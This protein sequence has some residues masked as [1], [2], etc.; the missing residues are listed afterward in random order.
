[1]QGFVACNVEK[2]GKPVIFSHMTDVMIRVMC[3]DET[4]KFALPLTS[5]FTLRY[6]RMSKMVR[7]LE[8]SNT[9]FKCLNS[10]WASL[11]E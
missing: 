2:R 6:F 11:T 7:G 4:A 3:A 5:F 1:M 10:T 9:S 8:R